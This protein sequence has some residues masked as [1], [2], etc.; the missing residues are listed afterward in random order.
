MPETTSYDSASE[1]QKRFA[2]EQIAR[3]KVSGVREQAP[4]YETPIRRFETSDRDIGTLAHWL[5]LESAVRAKWIAKYTA[6]VTQDEGESE[7]DFK[8]RAQRRWRALNFIIQEESRSPEGER[9]IA[10]AAFQALFPNRTPR[11]T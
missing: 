4:T 3:S 8:Q 9:E 7:K 5:Q 1:Y 10:F 11:T 6:P 2:A